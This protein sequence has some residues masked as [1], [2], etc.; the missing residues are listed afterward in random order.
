MSDPF[1]KAVRERKS[2]QNASNDPSYSRSAR[3]ASRNSGRKHVSNSASPAWVAS[4][5]N[6]S[7]RSIGV[8]IAPYP[9][10]DLPVI[11]RCAALGERAE[12]A[13]DPRHDLVTQ[14]RVVPARAGGVDEL[15]P[16]EARPAVD[17]HHDARRNVA[18]GEQGV[19]Q[20]DR[21]RP[22]R[23]PVA[24]HVDLAAQAL[25]EID[26]RV[27]LTRGVVARRQ[28]HVH[29][30]P[31]RIA[32][33]IRRQQLTVEPP[34]LDPTDQFSPPRLHVQDRTATDEHRSSRSVGCRSVRHTP[35][36]GW[37]YGQSFRFRE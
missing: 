33:R 6:R 27:A 1:V 17:H 8:I 16:A 35:P 22:E 30:P 32:E 14:V 26:R 25:D 7:G 20:L 18:A 19:D 9:P 28:V 3:T 37:G 21:V 15:A 5:P 23:R 24:P 29:R 10:L 11:P 31:R 4:P 12:L 2:F 13:I 36:S 34:L